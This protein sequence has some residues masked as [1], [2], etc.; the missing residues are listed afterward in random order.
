MNRRAKTSLYLVASGLLMCSLST[1]AL[2]CG[3]SDVYLGSV[4]FSVTE[5]CPNGYL[6][7]NGQALSINNYPALYALL[8]TTYGGSGTMF[9]LPDLRGRVPVG[10]GTGPGLSTAVQG[11]QR[12]AESVMLSVMNLPP[13]THTAIFTPGSSSAFSLNATASPATSPTPTTAN[14]QL[15]ASTAP[16]VKI[17]APAGG[18]QVPLAGVGAVA[19]TVQPAG[20]GTLPVPVITPQSVLR[21]CIAVQGLY[22]TQS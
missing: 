1:P 4:C 9:N 20:T 15:G 14:N 13:H 22:P 19:V 11:Q 3:E 18:T 16:P 2:A 10:Q 21:A 17:Y 7:A 5:F 6:D 8:G 12:G